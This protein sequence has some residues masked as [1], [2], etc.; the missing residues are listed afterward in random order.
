MAASSTRQGRYW[1]L[2]IIEGAKVQFGLIIAASSEIL[3]GRG[4]MLIPSIKLLGGLEP[5]SPI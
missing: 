4:P 1:A 5:Q 3:E 2:L